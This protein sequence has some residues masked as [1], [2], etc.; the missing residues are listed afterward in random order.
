MDI[1]RGLSTRVSVAERLKT[2]YGSA[3]ATAV[4]QAAPA[5]VAGIHLNLIIRLLL[6][7]PVPDATNGYRLYTRATARFLVGFGARETGYITLSESIDAIRRAGG[8][9]TGIPSH[10]KN[11]TEGTSKT[12]PAE[13]INALRGVL[14]IRFR[15]VA[16]RPLTTEEP[17]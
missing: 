10:F 3:I 8:A 7:L 2:L 11:R 17:R 4:A 16:V 6:W 5:N 12:G 1:A 15:P 14:R 13:A 9:I